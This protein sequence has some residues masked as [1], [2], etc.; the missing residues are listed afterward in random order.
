M[1]RRTHLHTLQKSFMLIVYRDSGDL[2][3]CMGL[4]LL[5]HSL[6]EAG[7]FFPTFGPQH[8]SA[9]K[10]TFQHTQMQYIALCMG[11]SQRLEDNSV[12]IYTKTYKDGLCRNQMC[13]LAKMTYVYRIPAKWITRLSQYLLR[14]NCMSSFYACYQLKMMYCILSSCSL[15]L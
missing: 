7:G 4:M 9:M 13:L 11:W 12:Q 3:T 15:A 10:I 6:V 14:K 1:Q 8:E 2:T 5:S